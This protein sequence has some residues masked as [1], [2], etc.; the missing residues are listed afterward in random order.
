MNILEVKNL[1]LSFISGG[2]EYQALHD[3][4]L[5]LK[6]GEMLALVGESGCGKT[7]TAMSVLKLLAPNAKITS[8][9]ILYNNQNLLLFNEKEMQQIRGKEIALVPQDPMTSLN[10]LYTIESQ[11]LEIIEQ[12]QNLKGDEAKK[13][14]IDVLEQVKIPNAKERLFIMLRTV[15][16]SF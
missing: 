2:K 9:E 11:L 14:A 4:D 1:N 16:D 6:K 3:V 12:H 15:K 7:I 10:P 13:I 5:H 8:G